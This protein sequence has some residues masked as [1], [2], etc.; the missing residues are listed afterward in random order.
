[1][2]NILLDK[3]N[4]SKFEKQQYLK[5]TT[6]KFFNDSSIEEFVDHINNNHNFIPLGDAEY[7]YRSVG[8]KEIK[9]I[10]DGETIE[11]RGGRLGFSFAK[12]KKFAIFAANELQNKNGIVLTFDKDILLNNFRFVDVIPTIEWLQ[13][14]IPVV[15]HILGCPANT[16][17]ICKAYS[18]ELLYNKEYNK[19]PKIVEWFNDHKDD[20]DFEEECFMLLYFVLDIESLKHLL[21]NASI[22]EA[23]LIGSYYFIP[24]M[25]KDIQCANKK[26][27]EKMYQYIQ[28]NQDKLNLEL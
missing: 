5:N 15:L 11:N 22:N 10:I 13:E 14:N 23:L 3:Y 8:W 17:S 16:F 9:S 7:L 25:I 2:K 19:N 20:D 21:F 18:N 28:D 6:E 12:E 1:M 26:H 24:G 27:L 4:H